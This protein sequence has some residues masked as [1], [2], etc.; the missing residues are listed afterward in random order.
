MICR[1]FWSEGREK[2]IKY[3]NWGKKWGK[4]KMRA[5]K[6]LYLQQTMMN[7]RKHLDLFCFGLLIYGK[8]IL[9]I[10]NT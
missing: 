3:M 6:P 5:G 9:I 8:R 2:R 1:F 7:L 4:R 10:R